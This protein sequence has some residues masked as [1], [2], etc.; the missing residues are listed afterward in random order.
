MPQW[1]LRGGAD[2][3]IL[4]DFALIAEVADAD[5]VPRYSPGNVCLPLARYLAGRGGSSHR[6]TP[7]YELCQLIRAIDAAGHGPDRI[8]LFFLGQE[9]VSTNGC[10][11]AL[12]EALAAGG[13]SRPGFAVDETG[14]VVDYADGGFQLHYARMPFLIGLYEFVL[15]MEDFG[16]AEEFN[17]IT[18]DLVSGPAEEATIRV[19]S[20]ALASRM[21][22]YRREHLSYMR[23]ESTFD[24]ILTFTRDGDTAAF[25]DET[26]LAFWQAHNTGDFR[27]YA[28]AFDAFVTFARVM[29][30]SET[31]AARWAAQTLDGSADDGG[32]DATDAS[33][34]EDS[35]WQ[36][37]LPLLDR[38]PASRIRFLT[39]ATERRALDGLMQYG[40]H[41]LRLPLSFL[42]REIFGPVQSAI[43]TD[44]Q[45]RRDRSRVVQRLDCADAESYVGWRGRMEE[46]AAQVRKLQM[47]SLHVLLSCGD[48]PP[49]AF[50]EV[51]EEAARAALLRD[52]ARIFRKIGRRGFQHRALADP[53]H[54]EGFRI[55]ADVLRRTGAQ[56]DA[57]LDVLTGLDG[58]DGRLSAQYAGDRTRFA[59]EFRKLYGESH[60]AV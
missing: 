5:G 40:P 35:D 44:L 52:C 23:H 43:T 47:A 55:G 7:L 16:F 8:W 46:L 10:R 57:I 59:R 31:G 54:R 28:T 9:R 18:A 27:L 42:R 15:G 20:N 17:T 6:D 2:D 30:A 14:I 1:L 4:A 50:P 37:P 39:R 33:A 56:I 26:I 24:A 12:R 58:T 13:W 34:F 48:D 38:D 19:A 36:S 49:E 53:T 25:D 41:A 3:R 60:G 29:A 32:V 11:K 51:M 21:R 22:R 45:T